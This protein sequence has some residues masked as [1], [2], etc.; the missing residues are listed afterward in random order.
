MSITKD[1]Y[2]RARYIVEPAAKLLYEATHSDTRGRNGLDPLIFL[3]GMQLAIDIYNVALISKIYTVLT[4]DLTIEDQ[5]DLGVRRANAKKEIE[6]IKK[7]ELYEIRKRITKTLDFTQKRALLLSKTQRH[8]RRD[9]LDAIVAAL[10]ETTLPERPKGSHDFALDG[11]GIWAFEKS[12]KRIPK[13]AP[14]EPEHDED[15][16]ESGEPLEMDQEALSEEETEESDP[17]EA[18]CGQGSRGESDASIG[19]KTDKDG[20]R[21][22]F[23]GYDIEACVRVPAISTEEVRVRTEPNLLAALVVIP[24]GKDI[25]NPCLRMLDRM[26]VSGTKVESILVDRHYSYKKFDRWL[27]ELMKRGIEQVV[28]SHAKDQGFRDWD[29][30]KM[31]A[32]WAHCPGTPDRLGIIPTLGPDP[33]PEQMENFNALINERRAY[34]AKRINPLS[35][36][37]KARY[38]CPA[39]DGSIGCPLRPQTMATAVQANLPIVTNVPDE[40]GRPK[41]C[42]QESVQIRITKKK[43][44]VT[45]KMHQRYYWGSKSWRQSYNR[46]TFVEGWFG[47]LKNTSSTGFHRGSHQFVGLPLVT[48]VVAMA[49]ATTNLRLLRKWHERTGFGDI[50]HPLL[51]PDEGFLGYSRLTKEQA[52]ELD[53]LLLK[54]VA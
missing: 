19:A 27:I 25:V 46:R 3:T 52:D 28:D 43:E 53:A 16:L 18:K 40:V 29:G 7:S 49:A 41:I 30:M 23:F 4:H 8:Q 45:M 32:A 21:R 38:G 50:Q 42:T 31:A 33:T 44:E 37:G 14:P 20:K 24:G 54:K 12:K 15:L 35:A 11:S 6:V 10:L 5:D 26:K 2:R 17:S 34:A 22:Y 13:S 9:N 48:L 1:Q 51:Q 39:L 36:D 47:V